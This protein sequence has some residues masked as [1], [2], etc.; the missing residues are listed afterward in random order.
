MGAVDEAVEPGD[1]DGSSRSLP[2][3]LRLT[4]KMKRED[5]VRYSRLLLERFGVDPSEFRVR[6]PAPWASPDES[7]A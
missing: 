3:G 5:V 2:N 1:G 6:L 7:S 4:S